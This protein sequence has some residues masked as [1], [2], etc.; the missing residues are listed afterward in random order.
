MREGNGKHPRRSLSTGNAAEPKEID[1]VVVFKLAYSGF[2]LRKSWKVFDGFC[3]DFKAFVGEF[4]DGDEP[5][6]ASI[7]GHESLGLRVGDDFAAVAEEFDEGWESVFADFDGLKESAEVSEGD[8]DADDSEESTFGVENWG[9]A[10]GAELG[11]R[12]EILQEVGGCPRNE[13]GFLGFPIALLGS[14]IG[15]LSGFLAEWFEPV[16]VGHIS[17]ADSF[18]GSDDF[19]GLYAGA[20]AWGLG[21]LDEFASAVE[22]DC[23]C[24]VVGFD[25]D[26]LDDFGCKAKKLF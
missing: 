2:G 25:A 23:N 20:S 5:W 14:G 17:F 9:G 1:F 26:E 10:D 19:G 15:E 16:A 4:I 24:G 21:D 18:S 11:T 6:P 7:G 8:R 3:D 12:G 13:L 22:G